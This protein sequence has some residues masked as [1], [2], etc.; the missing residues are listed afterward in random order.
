MTIA[1]PVAASAATTM[2]G[3]VCMV[4]LAL[5]FLCRGVWLFEV[6]LQAQARLAETEE[7]DLG[8]RGDGPDE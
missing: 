4:N 8:G 2:K 1:I 3:E 5:V 7:C 6:E